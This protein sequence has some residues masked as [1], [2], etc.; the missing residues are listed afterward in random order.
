MLVT[1]YLH[2]RDSA[3]HE[4][5]RKDIERILHTWIDTASALAQLQKEHP[6]LREVNIRCE[7]L[8]RLGLLGIE[9]IG[10]IEARSAASPEWVNAEAA[11]ISEAAQH[12]G[13]TDFVVLPPLRDL[14]E[15][16]AR[17]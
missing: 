8:P 13:L 5:D 3:Q 1:R 16:A 7:Q 10:A 6:L 4:A 17:P 11:L 12:T 9:A 2:S 15:A 14:L